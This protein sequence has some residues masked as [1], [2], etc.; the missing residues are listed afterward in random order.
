VPLA[1]VVVV[2]PMSVLALAGTLSLALGR[3]SSVVRPAAVLRAE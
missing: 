2:L 3:R 1:R